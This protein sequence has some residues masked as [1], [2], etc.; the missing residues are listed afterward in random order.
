M[1]VPR[2]FLDGVTSGFSRTLR[3]TMVQLTTALR[4]LRPLQRLRVHRTR[5]RRNLHNTKRSTFTRHAAEKQPVLSDTV[6]ASFDDKAWQAMNRTGLKR[7]LTQKGVSKQLVDA[8]LSASK[9][10]EKAAVLDFAR[11]VDGKTAGVKRIAALAR[12]LEVPDAWRNSASYMLKTKGP[13]KSASR[14]TISDSAKSKW[15]APNYTMPT[16]TAVGGESVAVPTKKNEKPSVFEFFSE[17]G[18]DYL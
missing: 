3:T 11:A 16:G 8:A 15:R 5:L 7:F 18:N 14:A 10:E 2:R 17:Y 6:C 13:F 9:L 1:E 12:A 4:V